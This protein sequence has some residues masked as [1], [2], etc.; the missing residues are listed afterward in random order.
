MYFTICAPD[1]PVVAATNLPYIDV[2]I[3]LFESTDSKLLTLVL[4]VKFPV[5]Y[6]LFAVSVVTE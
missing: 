4:V 1:I 5:T 2:L 3:V 6:T